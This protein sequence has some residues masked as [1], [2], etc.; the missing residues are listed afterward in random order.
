MHKGMK[1]AAGALL[2]TAALYSLLGFLILPGI[3]LRIVNQQLAHYAAVPAGLERLQF[4]PF[5]LELD[6]WGLRIGEPGR[7]HVA[8]ERLYANLQLD[9]LWSGALHL[10]NIELEKGHS[11]VLFAK[12]GTLNLSALFKLP[13]DEPTATAEPPGEPFP[14][15][16]DHL[17]LVENNLHFQDLRPSEAV[18]FVYDSLNLELHNLSTLPDDNANMTLVATGPQG[19]RIDWQGQVSLTPIASQGHLKVSDGRLKGIWPYVRDAVPLVLAQGRVDL[20]TDYSLSLA[21]GTELQLSNLTVGLAPFA[22]NDPDGK[23]LLRLERLDISQTSVDLGKRQVLIGQLRSRNLEAWAAR[24]ADGQLD[25]QKLLAGQPAPSRQP[26]AA[27]DAPPE[28]PWQVLL[29]D[30]QLRDYRVHLL[31]RVPEQE[32]ALD[33]GPLALDL[34]DFDSL[35]TSPFALKLDTGL[36][37]QGQLRAEGHV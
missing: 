3:G 36:G 29:R 17:Q 12:D 21:E 13:D 25:W 8:F 26:A 9:S 31:D 22:I 32:V 6:L 11:A 24:E 30:G 19:G 20:S 34:Q 1:R 7:E 27:Q 5:S 23:P 10:A 35:G 28:S 14:L 2:L 33:L 15:R 18:E 16:I 4:N 37:K